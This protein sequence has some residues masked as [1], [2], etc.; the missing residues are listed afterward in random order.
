MK[1][2]IIN[3]QQ[4]SEAWHQ[5]RARSLNASEL[6]SA[7]GMSTYISRS[8][9]IKQKA[10]GIA[11]EID[12]QTQRRFDA[13]HEFEAIARIWAEEIIGSDLYPV[14][15]A[16][17]ADGLSLSASLDG[18][19]MTSDISWE[20][21]TGRADLLASLDQGVIPAEYHP[22]MEM[23]LMLSGAEKC[24]FMASSGDKDAMRSA[25]YLPNLELRAK[26]IPTWAQFEQDLATY[27]P[28]EVVAPVVG[29]TPETLPA[30]LIELTGTVTVSNLPAYRS[31]ALAV[32]G[33]INRLLKTDQHFADAEKN[34]KWCGEVE[35]RV[36]AAKQHALAQTQSIDQ[37]FNALDDIAGEA[38]TLR[39]ELEKLV[40]AQKESLRL[41][42]LQA[43][44]DELTQ[45]VVALNKRLGGQYIGPVVADF[46]GAMKGKRTLES[47][48]DAVNTTLAGAKIESSAKADSIQANLTTLKELGADHGFLFADL[49]QVIHK[50][51]EDFALLVASRISTHTIA[52]AAQLEAE[53]EKIRLEEVAKLKVAT[54]KAA[55]EAEQAPAEPVATTAPVPRL[56]LA[57]LASAPVPKAAAPVVQALEP[58]L[59]PDLSAPS[60]KLGQISERLGFTLTAAFLSELGFEPAGTDKSAKLFHERNFPQICA[61]L[62][63]HIQFVCDVEMA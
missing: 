22:Q 8:K 41:D 57:A 2:T 34:I 27:V 5:H 6:A 30:L 16:G 15:L 61:A 4:G 19:T 48:R 36:V 35:A 20:H 56:P 39:L 37:L 40:K 24:L 11:P 12:S 32:F 1:T 58:L 17:E 55:R 9:L 49:H 3:H 14:V 52:K 51:P 59:F 53:R 60:L 26:I 45:H 7:M 31:H 54:D 33:G 38:R 50:A 62:V 13:G 10:T 23:G 46:A 42:M 44:K 63:K 21:K 25:W 18:L 28:S 43:G 29:R 47:L